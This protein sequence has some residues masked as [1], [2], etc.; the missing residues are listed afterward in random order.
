[1]PRKREFMTDDVL[2]VMQQSDEP[3]L[4]VTEI[5]EEVDVTRKTVND[6]LQELAGDGIVNRKKVGG[7][8]VVWWLPKRYQNCTPDAP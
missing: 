8:A 4:T 7:R 5:L 1:M 3:F 6:R 2:E